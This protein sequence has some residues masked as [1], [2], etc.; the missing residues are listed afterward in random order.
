MIKYG[1]KIWSNNEHL[2]DEVVLRYKNKEFDFVELYSN[3][4]FDHNYELLEK[5]KQVPI[6]GIHIGNLDKA[7]FHDFYLKESQKK[8]WQM[9]ID[10]ADFFNASKIIV[11]PAVEHNWESFLAN[12][13]KIDDPRILIESMPVI[14]PL[15]D[16]LREF[17]TSLDDLQKIKEKKE[18][19]LDVSKSIKAAAYHKV[20]YK[21]FLE[22][23][24][25]DLK[26]EYFHISG[27]DYNSPIDQHD[28]LWDGNFDFR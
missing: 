13:K 27:G 9:T 28:N 5:L 4:E 11:H 1:L 17:G 22:K 20:D 18:I 16:S 8:A 3:S 23:A 19:C 7:G 21:E 14:S 25:K 6:L 15:S 2:F 26:S 12:L 10:L 24:L